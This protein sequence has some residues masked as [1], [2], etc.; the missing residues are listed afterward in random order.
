MLAN[1]HSTELSP[2]EKV[3]ALESHMLEQTQVDCPVIHHFGPGIYVREVHLPKGA[4]ALGHAQKFEHLNIML[5]GAVAMPSEDGGLKVMKA[6]MIY[7][8]Q[9]GRKF[10]YVL[11]D[12]VWQ[13]VYATD[14]T[15]IDKLESMFLDKSQPWQEK[16]FSLRQIREALH[17]EDRDDFEALLSQINLTA[18]EVRAQSENDDD[19]IPMPCGFANFTVRDSYIEGKGVFLSVGVEKNTVI[20]PARMGGK[21]TPAGRFTNHAKDANAA[22]VMSDNGDIYLVAT[23][24]ISGCVGGEQGEE[25]TVNYRQ[26][27]SLSGTQIEDHVS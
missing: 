23:K 9:P 3:E 12:V 1:N 16:D 22:F 4:L 6:P 17:D 14:E 10:G 2:I 13:N 7:T 19:Q 18:E 24:S 15:D 25:V 21:R 8:G 27:L 20:A 5:R 26:A 11:E